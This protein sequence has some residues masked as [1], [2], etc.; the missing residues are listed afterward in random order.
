MVNKRASRD[1]RVSHTTLYDY[2]QT[3]RVCHNL[4]MLTPRS[5][6]AGTL[7][8]HRI[9][10][11]PTPENIRR[12]E[13]YFGNQV[14]A[15]SIDEGHR[16]LLVNAT[17]RVRVSYENSVESKTP[18]E[19][20][21]ANVISQADPRWLEATQFRFDSPRIQSSKGFADYA[22]QSFTHNRDIL[23]AAIELNERIFTD[24]EY[25]STATD[26][27]TSPD[28]AFSL[29]KGVCQDFAQVQIACLRSIGL[30][31]RYVSGYLR[32]EPLPG[33]KKLIGADQSHAWVSIY[34][35]REA[36]W[37]D[38]DPTNNKLCDNDHIPLA[39]GRDF[40]DVVPVRG[41][42]LGGGQHKITVSVDVSLVDD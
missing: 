27:Y 13:D 6:W 22:L 11:K 40:N 41:V 1:Y 29:R 5:D 26:A 20:V 16:Q 36:G 9:S 12:H 33:Q 37:I 10:V 17:G 32:T 7:L 35:G 19:E 14:H 42:F 8:S 23:S 2:K 39:W 38:M 15:F 25:D 4:L 3:V 18:W 21:R 28:E 24:F 30:C 34:C 31:A